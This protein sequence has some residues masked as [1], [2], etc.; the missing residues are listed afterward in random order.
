MRNSRLYGSWVSRA[1]PTWVRTLSTVLRVDH[2]QVRVEV[3]GR[4][5]W[6][7]A[8]L[9]AD[10][11]GPDE[12]ARRDLPLPETRVRGREDE[13]EPVVEVLDDGREPFGLG[14]GGGESAVDVLVPGHGFCAGLGRHPDHHGTAAGNRNGP[15][16][17]RPV[18]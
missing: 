2:R 11:V 3:L 12:R 16:D 6:L 17:G 10:L 9:D 15:S 1:P 4:L 5:A 8:V 7:Q 18:S 14:A 13:F